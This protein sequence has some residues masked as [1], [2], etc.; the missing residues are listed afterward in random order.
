LK[1]EQQKKEREREGGGME[2]EEEESNYR[3]GLSNVFKVQKKLTS[4]YTLM[5]TPLMDIPT[6]PRGVYHT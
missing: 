4:G 3:W 1:R 6:N 2:E 5:D